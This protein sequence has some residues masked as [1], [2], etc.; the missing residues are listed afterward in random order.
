MTAEQVL[1]ALT[2]IRAPQT[3]DEYD[4]H[5]LT[6]DA[7]QRADIEFRH[8]APLASRCR[9][10]FLCGTVGIEIKRGRPDRHGQIDGADFAVRKNSGLPAGVP[11][12]HSRL[13]REPVQAVGRR[14]GGGRQRI[15]RGDGRIGRR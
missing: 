13:S 12:G 11:G 5:G 14:H 2:A 4:L 7:L 3:Q 6:A 15:R 9:I 8:E 1:L 10:D